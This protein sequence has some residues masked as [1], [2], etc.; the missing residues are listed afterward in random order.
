MVHTWSKK[1]ERAVPYFT[2]IKKREERECDRIW[3][4]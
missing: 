1:E 4:K 2:R 3:I